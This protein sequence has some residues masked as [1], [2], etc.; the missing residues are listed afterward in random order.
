MSYF[1]SKIYSLKRE[2]L[3]FTNKVSRKLSMNIPD[4]N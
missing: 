4:K 2:I 1:T 3:N